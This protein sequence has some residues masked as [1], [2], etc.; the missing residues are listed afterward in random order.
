MEQFNPSLPAAAHQALPGGW[1]LAP[2]AA[3]TLRP[4][5]PGVLRVADGVLWATFDGPHP[6]P[7]NDLGDHLLPPGAVLEVEAGQRLVIE[8]LDA[9][10]PARFSWDPLPASHN[11]A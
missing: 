8:P 7:F 6:G 11:L 4:S 1:T 5:H 9:V 10:V 2:G 3:L